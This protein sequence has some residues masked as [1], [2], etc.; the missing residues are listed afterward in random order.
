MTDLGGVGLREIRWAIRTLAPYEGRICMRQ[1]K[2]KSLQLASGINV[3]KL[4]STRQPMPIS[5]EITSIECVHSKMLRG[6]QVTTTKC[7][8]G[9]ACLAKWIGKATGLVEC[10]AKFRH[11]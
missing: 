10:A 8:I 2:F 5:A 4:S 9:K 6:G 1:P 3:S 11:R 7:S